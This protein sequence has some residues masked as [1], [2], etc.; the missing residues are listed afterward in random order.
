MRTAIKTH[1]ETKLNEIAAHCD[2]IFRQ[3]NLAEIFD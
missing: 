1:V 3:G 2:G